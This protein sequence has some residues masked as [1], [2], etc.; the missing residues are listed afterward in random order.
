MTTSEGGHYPRN[1]AQ[2]SELQGVLGARA[3][4][5][6][7]LAHLQLSA[8]EAATADTDAVH[9]AVTDTGVQVTVSAGFTAPPFTRN[10]TATAGG[11]AGDIKA[12]QVTVNGTN[13]AGE[14]IQEVLPAFTVDTAGTVQGNK[15]FKTV[16][17]VV[18]PAHD[19]LGATT[20]IGFGDKI[21]LPHELA[22]NTIQ[23]AF[24]NNV[25]EV[26]APTVTVHATNLEQN[27]VLLS[28]ALNGSVVDLY[29]VC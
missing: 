26:D 27:T 20:A 22:H 17:S 13:E 6:A 7:Y 16:T 12:I 18:I 1:P 2:P 10:I 11:T 14:V 25:E 21:G 3:V 8:A 15:A 19:G 24:L 9:A 29:Y 28:S 23:Q 5:R 4:D